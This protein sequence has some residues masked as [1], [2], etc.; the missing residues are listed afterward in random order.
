VSSPGFETTV[1]KVEDLV[2][3]SQRQQLDAGGF[4]VAVIDLFLDYLDHEDPR[5]DVDL[6]VQYCVDWAGELGR[7]G[8]F[9]DR[10]LR[11]EVEQQLSW[12]LERQAQRLRFDQM[13]AELS[14]GL[15]D[16]DDDTRIRLVDLCSHGIESHPRM[17]S[18]R[19]WALE[20]LRLAYDHAQVRA[21]EGALRPVHRGRLA[22]RTWNGGAPYRTALGY[23]GHLAADPVHQDPAWL[24]RAALV[25]L[26]GYLEV[27]ADAAVRIPPHLLD[28]DQRATL[29]EALQRRED[30]EQVSRLDGFACR[31]M[32][33]ENELL[34]TVLWQAAD[35]AHAGITG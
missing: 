34:R 33:R 32:R 25:D 18:T 21:L 28:D 35:C 27:G 29:L 30:V 4:T 16:G 2:V 17:F 12:C 1:Q 23:L 11:T 7:L 10:T 14:R 6:L 8:L 5:D 24:A 15:A 31:D 20:V 9:E 13:L 26:A 3:R 22:P 19:G